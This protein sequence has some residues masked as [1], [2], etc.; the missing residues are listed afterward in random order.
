MK[1]RVLGAVVVVALAAAVYYFLL[2]P[3]EFAVNFSAKTLPGDVIETVRIWNRSLSD[4]E[5]VK[6]DSFDRLLQRITWKGRC[7]QFDW[8][9]TVDNDSLTN[10]SIR[11]SEPGNGLMNKIMVLLGTPAIE[12]DAAAIA[13]AFYT[14]L[15][16]HLKIT[17]VRILGEVEMQR[18]FCICSQLRAKQID[19]ASGMMRDYSLLSWFVE[20]YQLKP[21]GSP[22]VRVSR[23]DHDLGT[24]EFDFCFPVE[25]R[26]GLP[27]GDSIVFRE[28][29]GGK[30]LKAEY[31]GNYITSY[32]AW[33]ELLRY[34][35]RNS[36]DNY[37]YPIEHFYNNPHTGINEREW[38][39]DIYLPLLNKKI[40]TEQ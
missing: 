30:A 24:L 10:V 33:Y 8:H 17:R 3:F 31:Y 23:W 37:G 26:E 25:R 18:K 15:N 38:K 40:D 27:E 13:R 34:A 4:A 36:Y 20:K 2:R 32:R 21:D 22:M 14:A 6:V 29:G 1:R 5:I 9:F 16:E 35:E 28:I 7:Y 39:A 19:K 11:I 12:E